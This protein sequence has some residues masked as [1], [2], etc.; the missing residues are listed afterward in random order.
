M[1][2]PPRDVEHI[3]ADIKRLAVEYYRRTGR[4]IGAT[5]EIAEYEAARLLEL[6][7]EEARQAGYD[8]TREMDGHFERIQIKG[9]YKANGRPWG[10]VGAIDTEK[11]FDLVLLVLMSGPYEVEEI[12]E[13][14]RAAVVER[15]DAPGSKSRNERRSLGVAQFISIA[16]RVWP[17]SD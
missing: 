6:D 7:L 12:W 15:L 16:S 17:K 9:R 4:P 11:P 5:G 2:E 10:R 3:M 13:A 1:G 8:A 14:S